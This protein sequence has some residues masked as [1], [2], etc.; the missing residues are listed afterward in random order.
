MDWDYFKFGL[1]FGSFILFPPIWFVYTLPF[2]KYAKIPLIKFI[3]ALV[4]H[5]FLII[6]L[7]LVCTWPIY[8]IYTLKPASTPMWNEWLL[9]IWISGLLLVDLTNNHSYDGY[10]IFKP[11]ILLASG[12]AII[13]HIYSHMF[14]R[15]MEFF[16]GIYIRNISLAIAM[17][18]CFIYLLEFMLIHQF[19]GRW[20][21]ILQ[22]LAKPLAL[23]LALCGTFILGFSMSRTTCFT[24]VYPISNYSEAS[25]DKN[26]TSITVQEHFV[27]SYF[28]F[29][30]GSSGKNDKRP[31]TSRAPNWVDLIFTLSSGNRIHI[32]K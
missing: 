10:K 14:L 13:L 31:E 1:L 27:E 12:F 15:N 5:V 16:V 32:E 25:S 17:L 2:N 6:L 22:R 11:L 18:C 24:N 26:A 29:A 9:Y 3:G 4:S 7:S 8:P 23:Y 20:A 19:F 21:I 30:I 28:S